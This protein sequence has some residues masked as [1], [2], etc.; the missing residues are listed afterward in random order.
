MRC[1]LEDEREPRLR[2]RARLRAS[3]FA[4]GTISRQQAHSRKS[5]IVRALDEPLHVASKQSPLYG[6]GSVLSY[7]LRLLIAVLC[8]GFVGAAAFA[9]D[10]PRESLAYQ[11]PADVGLFVEVHGL[12]DLLESLTE[13][14]I[15][16]TLAE[17]AG[18]PARPEEV[19]QWRRTIEAGIGMQPG[20]AI[21]RLFARGAAFVGEGL[22]GRRDAAL[23]CRPKEGE[24][25][26]ELLTKWDAKRLPLTNKA[27]VYALKNGVSLAVLNDVLLFGD[28]S[29]GAVIL[30]RVLQLSE[31]NNP[32]TLADDPTYRKLLGR[33]PEKPDAVLFVRLAESIA[34]KP[35]TSAPSSRPTTE[36][37]AAELRAELPQIL[38][39]ASGVLMALHRDGPKLHF[40][41][42]GDGPPAEASADRQAARI[43]AGLPA[44]TLVAWTGHVDYPNLLTE[45]QNLPER[46]MLRLA[47]G[48]LERSEPLSH[49]LVSLDGDT[50]VAVG[51]VDIE[52]RAV[53]APAAPAAAL[54]V[55]SADVELTAGAIDEFAKSAASVYN[56]FALRWGTRPLSPASEIQVAGAAAHSIDLSMLLDPWDEGAIRELELCWCIDADVLIVATHRDWLR[57]IIESRHSQGRTLRDV[58]E[59]S[60]KRP[61]DNAEF[62]LVLQPGPLGDLGAAWLRWFEARKPDMLRDDWWRG[63]QPGGS[64]V[65]LGVNGTE[66]SAARRLTVASVDQNGPSANLLRPDDAIIGCGGRKFATSQP[67]REIQ[68][69]IASRPDPRAVMLTVERG[70]K[71]IPVT[72]HV[73]FVNPLDVLKRAIAIGRIAQRAVYHESAEGANG[74][75]G[76]L[77]V[78]LRT[79]QSPLFEFP[80]QKGP[81]PVGSDDPKSP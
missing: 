46:N 27:S 68:E 59:I 2:W 72:I 8:S 3:A 43:A 4:D 62:L 71:V 67:V 25:I 18:Q 6:R 66:D 69:C 48:V 79:S 35:T 32:R 65:R 81:E 10:P 77:T 38:H 29:S 57:Q 44:R 53:G 26:R 15:W 75:V 76:H 55:R 34:K 51:V 13:P 24:S 49:L 61:A 33:V 16:L 64:M 31:Q 30:P 21:H 19:T 9:A 20:E 5:A 23:L 42:V 37:A 74:S 58:L 12:E 50:C 52:S 56:L 80:V 70:G 36:A 1:K 63:R 40:T 11:T 60:Q 54:L 78:E 14:S 73:P 39:G 17:L 22:G 47:L 7:A 41:A 45:S 28:S